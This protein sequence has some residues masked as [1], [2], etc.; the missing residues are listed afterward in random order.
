MLNRFRKLY[1]ELDP[2]ERREYFIFFIQ[3]YWK[4]QKRELW[5]AYKRLFIIQF[6]VFVIA[7]PIF[8]QSNQLIKKPIVLTS[9]FLLSFLVSIATSGLFDMTMRIKRLCQKL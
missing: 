5:K 7:F 2:E 8:S 4:M 6:S 1:N 3:Y 9:A